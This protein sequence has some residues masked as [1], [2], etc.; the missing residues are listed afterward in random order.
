[1]TP[2]TALFGPIFSYNVVS[3]ASPAL[4]AFTAYLLC[5]RGR[6]ELPAVVGGYLFGFSSYEFGQLLGHLNLTLIFLIPVMVHLALRRI[7]REISRRYYVLAMALV[8]ILQA[9]LS[10]ELARRFCSTRGGH[11][12]ISPLACFITSTRAGRGPDY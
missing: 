2:V 6:R 11:P 7:D 3:I 9:G 12:H 5:R 4:A 10:T 8:L 1:M